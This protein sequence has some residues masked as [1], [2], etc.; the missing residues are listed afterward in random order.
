MTGNRSDP[1]RSHFH[2]PVSVCT[3]FAMTQGLAILALAGVWSDYN[4]SGPASASTLPGRG[5][6]S[7]EDRDA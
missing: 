4:L 1:P 2:D 5:T 7:L 3:E 6:R